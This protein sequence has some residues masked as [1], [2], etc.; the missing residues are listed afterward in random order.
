MAVSSMNAPDNLARSFAAVATRTSDVDRSAF[1]SVMFFADAEATLIAAAD[2]K[3]KIFFIVMNE[4][5]KA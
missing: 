5:M 4:F 3:I 2:N 1:V